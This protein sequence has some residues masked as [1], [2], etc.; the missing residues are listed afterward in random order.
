MKVEFRNLGPVKKATLDM[1]P[2]TVVIGPNNTGKTHLAHT[3]YWAHKR[4]AQ[5]GAAQMAPTDPRSARVAQTAASVDELW[6]SCWQ[7]AAEQAGNEFSTAVPADPFAAA[8]LVAARSTEWARDAE[9]HLAD[10][11][12]RQMAK[13]VAAAWSQRQELAAVGLG[14]VVAFVAERT[15]LLDF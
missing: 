15:S 12:L 6:R 3:V 2:L 7:A 10:R 11:G 14:E 1:R 9:A 13:R 5:L 8:G 4:F